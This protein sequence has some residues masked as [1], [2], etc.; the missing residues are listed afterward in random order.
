M[1]ACTSTQMKLTVQWLQWPNSQGILFWTV[2]HAQPAFFSIG[3]QSRMSPP[4]SALYFYDCNSFL[5]SSSSGY[6]ISL[7]T[8]Y[9]ES[10]DHKYLLLLPFLTLLSWHAMILL[11]CQTPHTLQGPN[12]L[13]NQ[14]VH[15]FPACLNLLHPLDPWYSF[16]TLNI[17]FCGFII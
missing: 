1:E 14:S 16:L 7:L 8:A 6:Q 5:F 12:M 17:S 10:Y 9:Q 4:P 11:V 13:F 2:G 3:P 15:F